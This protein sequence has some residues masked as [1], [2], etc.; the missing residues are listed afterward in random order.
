MDREDA[1]ALAWMAQY[2]RNPFPDKVVW[3]QDDVTHHR[4]YWLAVPAE[5]AT[6]RSL[7]VAT[8]NGQRIDVRSDQVSQLTI[9][10]HDAMLDLDQPVEVWWN[11]QQVFNGPAPRRIATI[12]ATLADRGDPRAVYRGEITVQRPK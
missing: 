8:R 12:A 9:R 11:D 5:Q 10:L 2:R 6:A 7:I 4:F 3:Q 1:A